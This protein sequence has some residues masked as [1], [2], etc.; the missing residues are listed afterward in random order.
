MKFGINNFIRIADSYVNAKTDTIDGLQKGL[1]AWFCLTFNATLLDDRLLDLTLEEL[2]VLYYMHEI[3]RN[4]ST[5][6]AINAD[7]DSYEEWLKKE[8]GD[9][10]VSQEEMAK[11]M[12]EYDKEEAELAKKLPDIIE[13]DFSSLREQK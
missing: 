12:V 2:L 13:T 1:Q 6:E 3:R 4:P 10:Y 5:L 9:S 8:M 7:T 11:E